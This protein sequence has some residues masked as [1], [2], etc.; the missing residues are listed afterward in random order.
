[1]TCL[2][3]DSFFPGGM[4][5]FTAHAYDYLEFETG[6]TETVELQ[7]ATYFDA[8]DEAGISRLWGG[9]HPRADDFPARIMGSAIGKTACTRAQEFYGNGKV[10]LCHVPPG[11]IGNAHTISVSENALRAHLAHGDSI[12]TC[13]G[14][15]EPPDEALPNHRSRLGVRSGFGARKQGSVTDRNETGSL[16]TADQTNDR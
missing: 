2:T 10:T 5:T 4:G 9:I 6:P 13:E 7:W 1:M 12:E 14:D 11:N 15:T 16:G 8:A 3:G